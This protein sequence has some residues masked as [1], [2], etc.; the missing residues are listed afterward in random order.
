MVLL[1]PGTFDPVHLGHIELAK[2]AMKA[3]G[4]DE[5]WLLVDAEPAYK[6]NVLPYQ[7]RFDM[8]MLAT[9]SLPGVSADQ[10]PEA[11]RRLPHTMAGFSA[12]MER[13]PDERFAFIVGLDMM[14]RLDT[15]PDYARVVDDAAFLVARRPGVPVDELESL[16]VRLGGL[17]ERLE[18]SEFEFDQHSEASSSV[19]R[20]QVRC[21]VVPRELDPRVFA[22]VREHGLYR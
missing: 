15:W 8:T 10:V 5:V 9:D 18:A 22:Y 6:A 11:V 4:L 1:L 3:G 7:Q 16:K 19:I 13:Y 12:L 2:A 21:G 17:G 14:R 20:E